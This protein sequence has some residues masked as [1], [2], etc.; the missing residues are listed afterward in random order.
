MMVATNGTG[1]VY[2]N[3]AGNVYPNGTGNV[4]PNGAHQFLVTPNQ[5]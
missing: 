5:V 3:G 1:N 4:Y 2:P